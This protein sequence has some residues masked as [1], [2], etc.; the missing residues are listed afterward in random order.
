MLVEN[1]SGQ[2]LTTPSGDRLDLPV[3]PAV[4]KTMS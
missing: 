1:S 2:V 4:L 3:A